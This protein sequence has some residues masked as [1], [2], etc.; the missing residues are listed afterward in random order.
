MK[1]YISTLFLALILVI[2]YSSNT[3]AKKLYKTV[4]ES[5]NVSFSDHVPAE[6]VKHRRETLNKEGRVLEVT[7]REKS[8][9]E[10]ARE[11]Q[12][13][14][15]RK[16]QEKI[17]QSQKTYDESLLRTYHSK[18]EMETEL[19]EKLADIESRK[20]LIENTI[21]QQTDRLD[22]A[23][24]KAAT[25]ERNRK[26]IPNSIL[27]D[28][29]NIQA[30]IEKSREKVKENLALQEKVTEEYKVNI[31]RFLLI[32][33]ASET[34]SND[35]VSSIQE[36]DVSGLF[37]C[38]NDDQC[39]KAWEIAKIFVDSFSTTPA[40]VTTDNLIMHSLPIRDADF[41]LSIAKLS[42]RRNEIFLFL[43]VHCRESSLGRELCESRKI[44][45]LRSSFRPYVNERLSKQ[46]A[47]NP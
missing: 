21:A 35:K 33:Q 19:K 13:K 24:K 5:G 40:D 17:I 47:E 28:I 26:P 7:E 29:K 31:K 3:Q 14:I 15:L 43:D 12:L 32:T 44:Q 1:T 9:E 37:R 36:A 8:K 30:D 18:Q 27:K 38:E 42:A 22:V 11:R 41:S 23:Q 10:Q 4:D 34:S 46:A 16:K 45:E 2:S 20:K 6:D 39:K 25:Y